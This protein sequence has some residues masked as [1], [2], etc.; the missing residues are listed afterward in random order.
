MAN[1]LTTSSQLMCPHGGTVTISTS[2]SPAQAAGSPIVHSNDTFTVTGCPF[3]IGAVAHPCTQVQ[4][5]QPATQN[6]CG[7]DYV[8]TG[9][10]AGMCIAADRTPQGTV[11]VVVAQPR[12]G[13][14]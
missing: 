5:I 6:Q 14:R 1:L 4:W 13:G 7:G 12:T 8:V 10:S 9:Q 2:N 3:T 11:Q